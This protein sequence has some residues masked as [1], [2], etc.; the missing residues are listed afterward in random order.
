MRKICKGDE[1]QMKIGCIPDVLQLVI[2]A[3]DVIAADSGI[4]LRIDG[5]N[6]D[7]EISGV[8]VPPRAL[9]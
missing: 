6:D 8:T 4:K 1:D 9:Q 3:S 7:N 2:S 5:M